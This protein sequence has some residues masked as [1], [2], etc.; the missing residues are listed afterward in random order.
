MLHAGKGKKKRFTLQR[1]PLG[2]Q[3][4]SAGLEQPR[5]ADEQGNSGSDSSYN[6]DQLRTAG[7]QPCKAKCNPLFISQHKTFA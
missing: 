6:T 3:R 2:W 7:P 1:G 5:S 4:R